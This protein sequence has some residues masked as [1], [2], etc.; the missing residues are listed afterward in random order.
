MHY[1]IPV[2]IRCEASKNIATAAA[3]AAAAAQGRVKLWDNKHVVTAE[4]MRGRTFCASSLLLVASRRFKHWLMNRVRYIRSLSQSPARRMREDVSASQQRVK[5]LLAIS[6]T[7]YRSRTE[8]AC[9][10]HSSIMSTPTHRECQ[11]FEKTRCS[12]RTRWP[13]PRCPHRGWDTLQER[14]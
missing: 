4:V 10:E 2:S 14:I 7:R 13:R 8:D 9:Q 6:N 11:T 1:G 12:E 3:A 5:R